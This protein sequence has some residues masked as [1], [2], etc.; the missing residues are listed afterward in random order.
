MELHLQLYATCMSRRG[1]NLP[2]P[3]CLSARRSLK[4]LPL[5]NELA[6][7]AL[8]WDLYASTY[9]PHLTKAVTERPLSEESKT[10]KV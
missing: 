4:G 5:R 6:R 9:I 2:L 7:T 8:G 1:R 3:K 10:S